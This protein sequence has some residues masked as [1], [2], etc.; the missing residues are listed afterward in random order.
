MWIKLIQHSV[1]LFLTLILNMSAFTDKVM[2]MNGI[3]CPN[4]APLSTQSAL[5]VTIPYNLNCIHKWTKDKVAYFCNLCGQFSKEHPKDY[6]EELAEVEE[7]EADEKEYMKCKHVWRTLG[8]DRMHH[9]RGK[10]GGKKY[11]NFRCDIC[12]KFQR[13]SL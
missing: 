8:D 2:N 6:I 13:R 12:Q 4:S 7:P 10:V 1:S 3:H 11:V 5:P 9:K